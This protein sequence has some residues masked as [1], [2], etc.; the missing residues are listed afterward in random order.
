MSPARSLGE[1]VA[2]FKKG[3]GI[4]AEIAAASREQSTGIEQVNRAMTQMEEA[5]SR[6]PRWSSRP[7]PPARPSSNRR[8]HSAR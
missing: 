6:T 2:A 1:I 3:H 8:R 5:R 4:V 7:L